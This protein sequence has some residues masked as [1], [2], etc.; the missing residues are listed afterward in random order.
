MRRCEQL[1]R[2][3]NAALDAGANASRECDVLR[4]SLGVAEQAS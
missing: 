2:E 1:E 3:R 4:R